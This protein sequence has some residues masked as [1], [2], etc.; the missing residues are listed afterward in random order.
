MFRGSA[1][2]LILRFLHL[3]ATVDD[4]HQAEVNAAAFSPSGDEMVTGGTDFM[5]KVSWAA[6]TTRGEKLVV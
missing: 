4:P 5:A 1:A 2:Q 6:R 3:Q